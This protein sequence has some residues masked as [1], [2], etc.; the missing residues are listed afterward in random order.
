VIPALIAA[1]LTPALAA[2]GRAHAGL[3]VGVATPDPAFAQATPVVRGAVDYGVVRFVGVTGELGLGGSGTAVAGGLLLEPVETRWWRVGVAAMPELGLGDL[4]PGDPSLADVQ[5]CGR[6]GL[7]VDWLAFWGLSFT[8]R[9]DRVLPLRTAGW[10][11]VA[12]G[13]AVRL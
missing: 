10:T 5:V 7:R 6:V 13:L 3:T 8:V 9:A 11:E 4:R 1:F 12:G 2:P